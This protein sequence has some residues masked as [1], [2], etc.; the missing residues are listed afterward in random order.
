[1]VSIAVSSVSC[2]SSVIFT[3]FQEPLATHNIVIIA[4]IIF[5]AGNAIHRPTS[6]NEV[7]IDNIKASGNLKTHSDTIDNIMVAIVLPDP[8]N[9]PLSVTCKPANPNDKAII[10]INK[11]LDLIVSISP[12]IKIADI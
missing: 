2:I 4:A 10:R 1:M 9:T 3:F 11:A 8:R 7:F 5:V 6:F 12:G